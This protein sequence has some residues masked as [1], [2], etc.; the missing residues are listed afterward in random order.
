MQHG[1]IIFP[2]TAA[3]Y[4]PDD[5]EF[6]LYLGAKVGGACDLFQDLNAVKEGKVSLAELDM[7]ARLGDATV[8]KFR[9]H[10]EGWQPHFLD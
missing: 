2:G 3:F 10:V 1:A 4:K 6:P 7:D 8:C 9:L 5:F